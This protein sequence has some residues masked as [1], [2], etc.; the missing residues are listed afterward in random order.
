[1]A[2]KVKLTLRVPT[3]DLEAGEQIEVDADQVDALVASGAVSPVKSAES[4]SDKS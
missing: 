2:G 4:K 3:L 1:M